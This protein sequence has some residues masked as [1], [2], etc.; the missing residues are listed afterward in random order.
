MKVNYRKPEKDSETGLYLFTKPADG[1]HGHSLRVSSVDEAVFAQE[2]ILKAVDYIAAFLRGHEL[3]DSID[4]E[5]DV[6]FR[7]YNAQNGRWPIP[8]KFGKVGLPNID[9][10]TDLGVSGL[11]FFPSPSLLTRRIGPVNKYG[12]SI[13]VQVIGNGLA[14][15]VLDGT[16]PHIEGAFGSHLYA[17]SFDKHSHL[18]SVTRTVILP[19]PV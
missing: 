14:E 17:E 11:T 7:V 12:D 5:A 19:V 3:P 1:Y 10:E 8:K 9:I 13:F 4:G 16:L 18:G 6:T 15:K 2:N